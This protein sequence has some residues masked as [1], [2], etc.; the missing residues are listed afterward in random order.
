MFQL[1]LLYNPP[2]LFITLQ[3][4]TIAEIQENEWFKKG[5]TPAHF[6]VEE[7]ITLDDVDAAFS[8]S[9]VRIL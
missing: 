6:E 2:F 7:D 8:S 9:R 1:L 4:I 3:R 5:F